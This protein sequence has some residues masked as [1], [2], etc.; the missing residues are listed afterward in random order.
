MD[1]AYD[2][3][4]H[5]PADKITPAVEEQIQARLQYIEEH[6]AAEVALL[7]QQDKQSLIALMENMRNI[8][9]Y[10]KQKNTPKPVLSYILSRSNDIYAMT[11]D[12]VAPAGPMMTYILL[13]TYYQDLDSRYRI[14]VERDAQNVKPETTATSYIPE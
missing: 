6:D 13:S 14:H 2:I 11:E 12:D 10:Y 1:I 3:Q 9:A 4:N 5:I 8:A 7:A